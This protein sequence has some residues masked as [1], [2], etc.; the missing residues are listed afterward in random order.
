[1]LSLL[2]NLATTVTA[3]VVQYHI[4]GVL[5]LAVTAGLLAS[6]QFRAKSAALKRNAITS[7]VLLTGFISVF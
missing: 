3:V 4:A 5:L 1:M 7:A 2:T 6:R